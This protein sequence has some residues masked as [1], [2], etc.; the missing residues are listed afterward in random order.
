MLSRMQYAS[1]STVHIIIHCLVA[2]VL[3]DMSRERNI[4][5]VFRILGISSTD[6]THLQELFG[7]SNFEN[8]DLLYDSSE[9]N[10]LHILNAFI[11]SGP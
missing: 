11:F 8:V 10:S 2:I 3:H 5:E 9:P 6:K 4:C 1:K 7:K